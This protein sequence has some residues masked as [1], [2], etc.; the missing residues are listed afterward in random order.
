[1]KR[2]V[3]A[4]FALAVT[5]GACGDDPQVPTTLVPSG[6]STVQVTGGVAAQAG[7]PPQVKVYPGVG[8]FIHTDVPYEF[9]RDTV[10]FMKT[11]HVDAA[12]DEIIDALIN[13]TG[14]AA[15]APAAAASGKPSGLAK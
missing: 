9:A 6:A 11:R 15:A 3:V 12:S 14:T 4:V 13:K 1:M 8:H 2:R 5:L 10:D 7:N